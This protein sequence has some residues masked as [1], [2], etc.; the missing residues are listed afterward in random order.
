MAPVRRPPGCLCSCGV[1]VDGVGVRVRGKRERVL[2]DKTVKV[3]LAM[4][5][6]VLLVPAMQQQGQAVSNESSTSAGC[7][8]AARVGGR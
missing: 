5:N 4:P 6:K 2:L 1:W 7:C 3:M 8:A